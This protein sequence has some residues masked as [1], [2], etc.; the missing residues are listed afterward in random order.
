MVTGNSYIVIASSPCPRGCCGP[1]SAM[2]HGISIWVISKLPNWTYSNKICHFSPQI[3]PLNYLSCPS[4]FHKWHVW[5]S[6]TPLFFISRRASYTW[7]KG[8]SKSIT[9]IFL[10]MNLIGEQEVFLHCIQSLPQQHC[11]Y[12]AVMLYYLSCLAPWTC[13]SFPTGISLYFLF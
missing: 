5:E 3:I 12:S 13:S 6:H 4:N 9:L 8:V 1:P 10:L 7:G 11:L 2:P